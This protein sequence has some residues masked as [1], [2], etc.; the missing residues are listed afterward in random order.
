MVMTVEDGGAD[1]DGVPHV[2]GDVVPRAQKVLERTLK[3]GIN[4]F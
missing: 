2:Q 4:T 1:D 3:L